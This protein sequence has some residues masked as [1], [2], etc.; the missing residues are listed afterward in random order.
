MKKKL[1]TPVKDGL[2]GMAIGTAI[3]V[4]GISGGMILILLG[5]YSPLIETTVGTAKNCLAGDWSNFGVQFGLLACFGVGVVVG[6]FL[7]SKLMNFFLKKYHTATFYGIFGFVLGSLISLYINNDIWNYYSVWAEGTYYKTPKEIEIP[8]G[9]VLFII[10][11]IL[12]YLLVRYENKKEIE[13]SNKENP[14]E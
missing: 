9:I 11:L 14:S 10:C 5:F 6:F 1:P 8:I 4:P 2:T 7:A 12:S 13:D 3:I